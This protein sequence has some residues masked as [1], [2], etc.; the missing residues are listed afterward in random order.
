MGLPLGPTFANIFMR[1][2][3]AKL[4]KDCPQHIKS[5]LYRRYVD[6]TFLL[7]EDKSHATP[8]LKYLNFQHI[9]I[10]FIL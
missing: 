4:L 10:K 3:E 7:F 1:F 8:F 9:N 6:D 2:R 5:F